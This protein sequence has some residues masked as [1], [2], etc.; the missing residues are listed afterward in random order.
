MTS[1]TRQVLSIDFGGLKHQI[2]RQAKS[3]G[4]RPGP[5]IRRLLEHALRCPSSTD[6]REA[7]TT[8][9]NRHLDGDQVKF[10][11]RLSKEESAA[12]AKRAAAA[13][14]SQSEFVGRLL[15]DDSART[16]PMNA[17]WIR[18]LCDSNH[19]LVGA[20][21][22]LN[23]LARAANTS[24]VLRSSDVQ[25][26]LAVTK[27]VREHVTMVAKQLAELQSSRRTTGRANDG[28]VSSREE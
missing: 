1:S 26:I 28:T 7:A 25:H 14:L 9:A 11:A 22:N 6:A 19:Q 13:G 3:E 20:S 8:A 21:R 2:E 24:G 18:A 27:L 15:L 16:G 10:T 23:Q 5:W 12:L 4:L 17:A